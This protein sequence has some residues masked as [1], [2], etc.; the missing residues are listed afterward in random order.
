MTKDFYLSEKFSKRGSYDVEICKE[1]SPLGIVTDI[2]FDDFRVKI[3]IFHFKFKL[4]GYAINFCIKYNI[5]LKKIYY[6]NIAR[7]LIL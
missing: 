1:G 6:Y 3:S 4:K 5:P 7:V 2:I